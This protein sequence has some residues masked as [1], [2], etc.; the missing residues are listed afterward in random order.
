[1]SQPRSRC[2]PSFVSALFI[3]FTVIFLSG[4]GGAL[5]LSTPNTGVAAAS[6]TLASAIPPPAPVNLYWISRDL[7]V[8]TFSEQMVCK[9]APT[10]P[11]PKCRE[12]DVLVAK[13]QYHLDKTRDNLYLPSNVVSWSSCPDGSNYMIRTMLLCASTDAFNKDVTFP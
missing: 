9:I 7:A 12:G 8:E 2:K 13:R 4:S 11:E 6:P 5:E 3:Y 10:D 1:M